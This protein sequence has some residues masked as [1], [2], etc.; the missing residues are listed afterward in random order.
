MLRQRRS[1]EVLFH[2]LALIP[3]HQRR[4]VMRGKVIRLLW[5]ARFPNESGRGIWPQIA[6]ANAM[7]GFL[8]FE[9]AA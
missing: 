4:R 5:K 6:I 2:Y 9:Q 3:F 1:L 7:T 8:H